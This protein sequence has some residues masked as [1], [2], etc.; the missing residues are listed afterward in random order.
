MIIQPY[1]VVS[2]RTSRSSA[3]GSTAQASRFTCGVSRLSAQSRALPCGSA[4]ISSVGWVSANADARLIDSVVLPVPPFWLTIA[5]TGISA[6]CLQGIHRYLQPRAPLVLC[7]DVHISITTHRHEARE[8][9][10]RNPLG[11]S[12]TPVT[13]SRPRWT[14]PGHRTLPPLRTPS[15]CRGGSVTLPAVF[16]LFGHRGN[17]QCIGAG[18]A[19]EVSY[20]EVVHL[21]CQRR[22]DY[23]RPIRRSFAVFP[24]II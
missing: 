10:L 8:F 14:L 24:R 17:R 3:E 4:S 1:L 9:R 5:T 2:L 20:C 23:L 12:A 21:G 16:R 18:L 22:P 6:S 19:A 11:S 7:T 15:S 13:T